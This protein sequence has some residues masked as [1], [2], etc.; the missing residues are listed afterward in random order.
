MEKVIY[1]ASTL[2]MMPREQVVSLIPEGEIKELENGTEYLVIIN[3][4][5]SENESS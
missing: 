3:S 4:Q 5:S 1:M 2:D